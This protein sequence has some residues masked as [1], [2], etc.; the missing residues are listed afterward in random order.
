M[1]IHLQRK[2]VA[3]PELGSR[4]LAEFDPSVFPEAIDVQVELIPAHDGLWLTIAQETP[5]DLDNVPILPGWER[6]IVGVPKRFH[7]LH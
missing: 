2:L 7:H 6:M 4:E 1:R 5:Q 3:T